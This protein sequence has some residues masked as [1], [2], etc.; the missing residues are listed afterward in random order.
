MVALLLSCL[1]WPATADL[2]DFRPT[3]QY[4]LPADIMRVDFADETWVYRLFEDGS[5]EKFVEKRSA[6]KEIVFVNNETTEDSTTS[7][8]HVAG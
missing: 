6:P 2:S 5:I 7:D 8:H 4:T 1:L 3:F